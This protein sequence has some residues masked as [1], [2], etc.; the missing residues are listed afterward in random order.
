MLISMLQMIVMIRRIL[1]DSL[2]QGYLDHIQHQFHHNQAKQL[3]LTQAIMADQ[4]NEIILK[5]EILQNSQQQVIP[6]TL[7]NDCLNLQSVPT[8]NNNDQLRSS[9]SFINSNT[10]LNIQQ[11]SNSFSNSNNQ[12][13]KKDNYKQHQKKSSINS[14]GKGVNSSYRTSLHDFESI[15]KQ[16]RNNQNYYQ[17]PQFEQSLRT[18]NSNFKLQLS[19][20]K[21]DSRSRQKQSHKLNTHFSGSSTFNLSKSLTKNLCSTSKQNS[22]AKKSNIYERSIL[23]QSLSSQTGVNI[24]E[25]IKSANQ[26]LKSILNKEND[27]DKYFE[28]LN[29]LFSNQINDKIQDMIKARDEIYIKVQNQNKTLANHKANLQSQQGSQVMLL[30]EIVLNQD[31]NHM[32]AQTEID[33]KNQISDINY[34]IN[35]K[36]QEYEQYICSLEYDHINQMTQY[37]KLNYAFGNQRQQEKEVIEDQQDLISQ[38]KK[39]MELEDL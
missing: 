7:Q 21:K 3:N 12:T 26:G 24:S 37:Q 22:S 14:H 9:A 29:D 23:S 11:F 25:L 30:K 33:L 31:I 8:I 28:N 4:A 36:G 5:P 35:S 34:K 32:L 13:G 17:N 2:Y 19:S 10:Y 15:I 18:S 1:V 6:M 39:K 20:S 38:Q 16:A 27:N